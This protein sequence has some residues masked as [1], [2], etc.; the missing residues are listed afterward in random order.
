[1]GTNLSTRHLRAFV[2]LVHTR[3]FTRAAAACH[4]SQPAFSAVIQSLEEHAGVRLFTRTPRSIALTPEGTLFE[5]YAIRL[6]H[7]F[8][9]AF[10]ELEDHVSRRKGRV[11]IATLASLA[12]GELP[13]VILEFRRRYPGIE[14]SL[15]DVTADVCLEL[16]RA[17]QVDFAVTA[18]IAPALDLTS[19]PLTSDGFHLVCRRD[20]PLARR[21]KLAADEVINLPMVR[22][23]RSSSIRQHLDA[24]F[25]PRQLITE[26][27]V[28]NLMTAAGL[29]ARGIGVTLVP[30]L[31]LFEFQVQ[32]LVA[33]PVALPIPDREICVI[34]R[35]DA[36]DSVAAAAFVDLLRA[37]WGRRAKAAGRPGR[38]GR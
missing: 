3:S 28:Y 18:A 7:D 33:I 1:M 31:A 11:A 36:A 2:A 37:R 9:R 6:L 38:P 15:K 5:A 13:P 12:G 8:D 34:R 10:K 20:H 21:K 4:L 26:M 27:E 29:V 16:L 24:A 17:D 22:F 35:K 30:T 25:Y 23:A 14:V 32:G 19:T